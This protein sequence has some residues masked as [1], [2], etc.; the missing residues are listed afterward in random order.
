MY[1]PLQL[2]KRHLCASDGC[3]SWVDY[4]IRCFHVIISYMA[5]PCFHARVF[6]D[7]CSLFLLNRTH[8]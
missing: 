4:V 8:V 6:A 2:R 5:S 3:Q 7:A 1:A